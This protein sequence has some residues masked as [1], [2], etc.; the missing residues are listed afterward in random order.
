MSSLLDIPDSLINVIS[1]S[2]FLERITLLLISVL[3]VLRSLLL[4]PIIFGSKSRVLFNSL[5]LFI[6]KITSILIFFAVL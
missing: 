2:I 4:I 6:S 3:K 5:S 1:L